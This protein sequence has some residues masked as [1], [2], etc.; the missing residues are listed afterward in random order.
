MKLD[1]ETKPAFRIKKMCYTRQRTQ[2]TLFKR[3]RL[4]EHCSISSSGEEIFREGISNSHL[5]GNPRKEASAS[6]ATS[7]GGLFHLTS[8]CFLNC[9]LFF[10]LFGILS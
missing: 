1:I 8:L 7:H 4:F 6:H 10:V 9:I 5:K 2:R 3:R